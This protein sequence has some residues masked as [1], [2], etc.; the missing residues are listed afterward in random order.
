MHTRLLVVVVLAL[1]CTYDAGAAQAAPLVVL[2][3]TGRERDGLPVLTEHD[4][5]SAIAASL[6]RG[7]GGV[8]LRLFEAAPARLV[9]VPARR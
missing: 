5:S 7:F 6:S 1:A 4:S 9:S 3:E 8:A 2:S